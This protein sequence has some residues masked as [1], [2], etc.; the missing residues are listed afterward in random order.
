M[1]ESGLP[2]PMVFGLLGWHWLRNL[3]RHGVVQVK[4]VQV[5]KSALIL[6]LM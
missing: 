3:Y 5:E 4:E 6:V 1:K 2:K